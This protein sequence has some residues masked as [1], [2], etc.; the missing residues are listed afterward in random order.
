MVVG[1]EQTVKI[2][3]IQDFGRA[4]KAG[5]WAWPGGY[6]IYF[7]TD[8]GGTFSFATAWNERAVIARA[9]LD[10]DRGGG[11]RVVATDINWEDSELYDDHTGGRIES[12][13]AEDDTD[14][15][16]EK[17]PGSYVDWHRRA[18]GL[19]PRGMKLDFDDDEGGLSV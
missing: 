17:I 4:L 11:W 8:D 10:D 3:T 14:E 2:Q 1:A 16:Y 19:S 18:H 12:A 15:S 6:P 7:I 13:Y 9:I 5:A